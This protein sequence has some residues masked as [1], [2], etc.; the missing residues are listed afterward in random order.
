MNTRNDN[1]TFRGKSIHLVGPALSL[2]T[3]A[4]AFT[5]VGPELEDVS[6]AQ[7]AGKIVVLSVVPSLDT[8]TCARQTRVF[9][10]KAASL[11]DDVIIMTVSL[12]L[13][14]AQQ[15]WCA[16]ESVNRVRV[17]SDY[18]Y[19]SFGKAYGTY[20]TDLGLLTRAVFVVDLSGLVCH[21]E[22][23]ENISNEPDYDT[24]LRAV[25]SAVI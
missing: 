10:E 3:P 7:F 14:F 19:R 6:S 16:A 8:S 2:G 1:I 5:L 17:A 15:R 25:T 13:P 11:S 9:N 12:D 22:Y 20:I 24:V 21:V 23:V 4:P 18:K